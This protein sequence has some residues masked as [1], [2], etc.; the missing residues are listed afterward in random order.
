[1]EKH[2]D[3]HRYNRA[4]KRVEKIKSFYWH[5]ASY[6]IVN[7]FM[8]CGKII[9]DLD[10][11]KTFIE[12]FFDFGTFSLWFFWGIGIFFHAFELFGKQLI[13]G[14]K[15]KQRKIQEFMK[16]EQQQENKWQ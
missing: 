9:S 10:E 13:F 7:I 16:K 6:L 15:W 4:K 12:A 2:I 11:R 14:E 5:F 1:M 3:N 8:S